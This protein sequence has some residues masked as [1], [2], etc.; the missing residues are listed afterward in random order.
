[1]FWEANEST[2]YFCCCCPS[3][4]SPQLSANFGYFK[5]VLANFRVANGL[6]CFGKLMGQQITI[7]VVVVVVV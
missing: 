5:G 3:C 4:H 6:T 1:M 2:N 7:V